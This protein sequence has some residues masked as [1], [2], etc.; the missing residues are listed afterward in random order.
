MT[1]SNGTKD[2]EGDTKKLRKKMRVKARRV[3]HN[4]KK[5]KLEEIATTIEQPANI[6]TSDKVI[7]NI[8]KLV[9]ASETETWRTN[10]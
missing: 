6:L 2:S 5:K 4:N 1:T 3:K 10:S 9:I 7:V 8:D